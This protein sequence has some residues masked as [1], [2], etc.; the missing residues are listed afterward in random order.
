MVLRLPLILAMLCLA[1]PLRLC[2]DE[3]V[4]PHWTGTHCL[5]C[6]DNQQEKTLRYPGDV[7]QTCNRCHSAESVP[8]DP[9]PVD[10]NLPERTKKNLPFSWPLHNDRIT[11][12]TCHDALVQMHDNPILQLLNPLFLRSR[13]DASPGDFCFSC[14]DAQDYRKENPHEQLDA[15]GTIIE[16]SCLSCHRS[17]PDTK[18]AFEAAMNS[19]RDESTRLCVSC[20]GGKDVNHP[21][22]GNHLLPLPDTMGAKLQ[23]KTADRDVYLPL[24][25][26]SI[27]CVTCHNPHQ[28]GVLHNRQA[29]SGAGEDDYLRVKRG[30]ALCTHCH[31]D[32]QVP[33]TPSGRRSATAAPP[34]P[35]GAL[36]HKP[37]IE[38]KCKACHAINGYRDDRRETPFLC[39]GEGC[40]ETNLIRDTVVHER[41]VLG[42]CTFC[43]SPHSSPYKKLLSTDEE[44]LCATCHPLLRDKNGP[45]LAQSDHGLFISYVTNTLSLPSGNECHFCHHPGHAQ[46]VQA[47]DIEVCGACHRYLRKSVSSSSHQ[48][49]A[50]K[51]CSSCHLPHASAHQYLL[52]EPPESYRR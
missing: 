14:H 21:V 40:H 52:R 43:H 38:E 39:F 31:S 11:C 3:M 5:E 29:A 18:A 15:T 26:N 7:I 22:W 24:E 50:G 25:N 34:R 6:H 42:S 27:A 9:H 51:A 45:P 30:S 17:V 4:N 8:S 10:V 2:A 35:E 49:Y 46:D 47:V 23:A 16:T 19:L 33:D 20:H 32:M 36:Q 12:L 13:S 37:Y 44:T 41:S 1:Q 28:Q 48:Q